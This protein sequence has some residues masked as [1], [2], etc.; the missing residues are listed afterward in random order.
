MAEF[1]GG[2][3]AEAAASMDQAPVAESLSSINMALLNDNVPA[4][5]RAL[6]DGTYKS[7]NSLRKMQPF[8]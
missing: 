3:A 7:Q 6:Y 1:T 5:P 4:R 8:A 2:R